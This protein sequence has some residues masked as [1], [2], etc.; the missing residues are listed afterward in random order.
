MKYMTVQNRLPYPCVE[1]YCIQ[2]RFEKFKKYSTVKQET[3]IIYKSLHGNYISTDL[4]T[5]TAYQPIWFCYQLIGLVSANSFII[6]AD[7]TCS[8]QMIGLVSANILIMAAGWTRI[9]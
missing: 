5:D 2:G 4:L 1:L 6:S 3:D 9:R 7:W 8:Y